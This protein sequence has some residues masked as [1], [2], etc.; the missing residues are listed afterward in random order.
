M[1]KYLTRFVLALTVVATL[2]TDGSLAEEPKWVK[3]A[4]RTVKAAI[5]LAE[6]DASRPVYHF[7]PPSQWMNDIYGAIHYKGYYH[8]FYQYNPFSGDRWG[9]NY[10]LWAHARSKD[11]VHWENLD[12]ALLPMVERGETRCNS[13]CVTLDG[14]G[15][16]MIFYT[17]VHAKRYAPGRTPKREQWAAIACDEDLIRWKRIKENPIMAAGVSGVPADVHGGW[18]DPFVFKSDGRTFVTYKSCGGL[19]GEAQNKELT[20]WKYAGKIDG[21][22]GECPNFFPLQGKWVLIR[23]TH[24]LSYIVGDFDAKA[25]SFEKNGGA[26]TVDY[27]FGK[28]PPKDRSWTR[29]LYGTNAFTDKDGR[30]ILVGWICGF[31][32]KRGWNGCMSLPRV[33][34]LDKANRLIQTPA[35]ELKKLRGKHHEIKG[36]KLESE[37]QLLKDIEGDAL[38]IIAQFA[39]GDADAFGLRLRQSEDGKSAITI[40]CA[41]GKL[42]VAGTVVPLALNDAGKLKL[43]VFIDRSV[44]EVFIND[45]RTSVTRVEYPGDKDLGVSVFAENGSVTLKSL[46]AWNMKSIW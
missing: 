26:G 44:L 8:I 33:L 39:G 24:P 13:G 32:P 45:G 36:L 31:K 46:D 37:A 6:K 21:V 20:K 3:R 29:G 22:S 18:S 16:P 34:T 11:L 2:V 30:R 40:R 17:F 25:I 10:S 1:F 38:E 9:Y 42:N 35:P 19:V 12:W 27:G 4:R 7:R 23:S 28:N 14:N 41:D 5:P 15:R 43:H